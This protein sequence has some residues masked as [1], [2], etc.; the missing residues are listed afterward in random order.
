MQLLLL[1]FIGGFCH[2][3][4]LDSE[5]VFSVGVLVVGNVDD[6]MEGVAGKDSLFPGV[7]QLYPVFGDGHQLLI[8]L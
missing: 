2:R 7:R 5:H 8:C 4:N 1:L 6:V 3:G